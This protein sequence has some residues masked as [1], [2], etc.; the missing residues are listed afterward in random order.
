[1][2]FD[3]SV[4]ILFAIASFIV[5]GL[6]LYLAC[7]NK[8]RRRIFALVTFWSSLLLVVVAVS[9]LVDFNKLAQV[10]VPALMGVQFFTL[11]MGGWIGYKEC[12]VP[13]TAQYIGEEMFHYRL[14]RRY[15]PLFSYEYD[16]ESYTSSQMAIHYRKRRMK[17]LFTENNEYTIYINPE[18]PSVCV[19]GRRFCWYIVLSV[20]A[21]A[22]LVAV[23]IAALFK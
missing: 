16:G 6:S 8:K 12:C 5:G 22:V 17:K 23:G 4:L 18:N 3:N 7:V 1:M 21:S 9:I 13:V 11:T 10:G 19:Y 15:R 2:L 14:G 20:V